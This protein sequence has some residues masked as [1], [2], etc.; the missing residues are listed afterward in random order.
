MS[1]GRCISREGA[2]AIDP[3]AE[4]RE[5]IGGHRGEEDGKAAYDRDDDDVVAGLWRK[6][7]AGVTFEATSAANST[8]RAFTFC[9]EA[10][11]AAFLLRSKFVG[12]RL[13][14]GWQRHGDPDAA[15][16][17]ATLDQV[18]AHVARELEQ[19]A[20]FEAEFERVPLY[21]FVRAE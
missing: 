7:P 3:L 6:Y 2:T 18:H 13:S 16:V 8:I 17:L 10:E 1:P 14:Q 9:S 19:R 20:G 21:E 11:W 4:A 15:A 5:G 12:V